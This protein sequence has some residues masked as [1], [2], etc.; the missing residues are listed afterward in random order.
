M[1]YFCRE[2]SGMHYSRFNLQ[3]FELMQFFQNNFRN[4][5]KKY[6]ITQNMKNIIYISNK[7][8]FVLVHVQQNKK[9]ISLSEDKF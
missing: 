4:L 1:E 9:F 3:F 7:H 6:N 8:T 5:N 2:L